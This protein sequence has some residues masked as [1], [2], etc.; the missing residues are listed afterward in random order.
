MIL[1][2]VRL[3]IGLFFILNG[4]DDNSLLKDDIQM[5]PTSSNRHMYFIALA[6]LCIIF[7]IKDIYEDLRVNMDYQKTMCVV[8]AKE[9][10]SNTAK[11]SPLV[12][13]SYFVNTQTYN[14]W[15]PALRTYPT[16]KAEFIASY[17]LNKYSVNSTVPCWYDPSSPDQSALQLGY[18]YL[19]LLVVLELI[20]F[21]LFIWFSVRVNRTPSSGRI[22][23]S[24]DVGLFRIEYHPWTI[25]Y[26]YTSQ[27]PLTPDLLPPELQKQLPQAQEYIVKMINKNGRFIYLVRSLRILSIC[28]FAI[29]FAALM[30]SFALTFLIL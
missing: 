4:I 20:C 28:C 18:H 6:I 21:A 14:E 13:V 23:K 5:N 15:I 8:L 2:H 3:L 16:M 26:I 7:F 24:V 9:L 1:A 12:E 30:I 11:Y 25:E 22:L 19:E 29:I 27:E 10:Q 17:L